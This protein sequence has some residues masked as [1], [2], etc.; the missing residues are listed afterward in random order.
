MTSVTGGC[1]ASSVSA[2]EMPTCL[3]EGMPPVCP[4]RVTQDMS[5]PDLNPGHD[6]T[7]A[8]YL[9]LESVYPPLWPTQNVAGVQEFLA[10]FAP[11]SCFG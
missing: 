5:G 8:A 1:D 7:I 3:R 6:G 2:C 9:P 10:L 11:V 4:H